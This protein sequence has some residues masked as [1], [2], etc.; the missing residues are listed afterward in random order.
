MSSHTF[1][2][3]AL[4]HSPQP[5]PEH[6]L[7]NH[8]GCHV[9]YYDDTPARAPW[10]A[11]S[12]RSFDPEVARRKQLDGCAVCYSLQAFG[13]ARTKRHLLCYRNLG[14]DIDLVASADRA[15]IS[16]AEIT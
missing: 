3:A 7:R 15:A 5:S 10:K 13:E 12:A 14:V 4:R 9:Q 11:L 2:L 6:F 16:P 1:S 8:P